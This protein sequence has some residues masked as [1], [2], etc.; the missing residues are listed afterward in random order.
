MYKATL[1]LKGSFTF[2]ISNKTICV[3]YKNGITGHIITVMVNSKTEG[4]VVLP[5]HEKITIAKIAM[6]TKN[7]L[8][9]KQTFRYEN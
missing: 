1:L 2:I 5:T 3:K 4:K 9:A 8:K 7:L 6:C